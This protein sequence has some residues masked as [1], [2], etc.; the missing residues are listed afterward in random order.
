MARKD[1][2]SAKKKSDSFVELRMLV[3]IFLGVVLLAFVVPGVL[4]AI[5]GNGD[6]LPDDWENQ[7]GITTNAF[8]A[9]NLVG[10]WQMEP[11]TNNVVLDRS[12]NHINGSMSGFSTNP[13][14]AGLFSNALSFATNAQAS[15]STN[16]ALNVSSGQFTFSTW[17]QTTN[18][19][20]QA[21]T[22]ATWEDAS[23]N[24][25]SLQATTNG[26]PFV[27][28]VNSGGDTQ[29]V[30]PATSGIRL[31]DG[32]WHQVAI[33]YTTNQVATVY[34]DGGS[35]ASGSI[36]NWTPSSGATLALGVPDTNTVN[37]SYGLDDTRL[38]NRA[39]SSAEVP[40]L[41][42]TYTDF[43]GNGLTVLEDYQEGLDPFS[44]SSIVTS[45]FISS[46]LV[47][48]Y[49][50]QLP[51]IFKSSGDV[52]TVSSSTF[53]TN[54]LV[55]QIKDSLGNPLVNAPVTFT[56]TSGSDGGLAQTSGGT[57][58][59]SLSLTTDGSGNATV[60][61]KAGAEVLQNNTITA[62]AVSGAGSVSVSFTEY[63][64]TQNGLSLWLKS[65]AGIMIDGSGNITG[66]NDQSVN[67]NNAGTLYSSQPTGRATVLTNSLNSKPVVHMSGGFAGWLNIVDNSSLRPTGTVTMVSVMRPA[68][69]SG[70]YKILAKGSSPSYAL[71][72]N[73][74]GNE[75]SS[76]LYTTATKTLTAT[77]TYTPGQPY[78]VAN[79]Y[80][81]AND[82]LYQSGQS[83]A[84]MALTGSLYYG[85]SEALT[86]GYLAGNYYSGDIA[87]ILVYNRALSPTELTAVQGY[88][89]DKWGVYAPSATWPSSY[90]S[91]VQTLI[92][93][94][95]WTKAQADAYVALAT[96]NSTIPTDMSLWLKA[97]TGIITD[98]NG[99]ITFWNDQ[100]VYQNNAQSLY[101][102]TQTTGRAT[103]LTNSLNSKSVVHMPGA[104]AGWLNVADNL[105][106][107]PTGAVTMISVMR[108]AVNSGNY[109]IL[110]KGTTPSYAL[111]IN[112]SGNEVSSSLYTTSTKTLTA[113]STYTPGQ[114]YLIANVYNGANDTL[115][116][117]GQSMATMALT[118]SLY[119]GSSEA[120]T[121]GYLGG[122]Y[123][124]GDIAE[125]LVYN[126]A[127]SPSELTAVQGYLADQ[128][129]VYAPSA[130]WPSSY[131]SA[132]Q[133]LITA[134]QW[135]KA[136]ADGYVAAETAHS[137]F[138]VDM[139]LWLKADAGVTTDINGNITGWNDQSVYQNNAQSVYGITQTTGRATLLTNSLNSNPVVHMPGTFADWLNIVD[140]SSLR[141]N[142]AVTM[143]S[144]MRPATNS[145]NYK[146]LAKGTTPSYSMGID[147]TARAI[148]SSLYTT[149]NKT[150][151]ATNI[152]TPGQPYLIANVY[153]GTNNSLYQ[154]GQS[155]ATMAL[156]GSL[157]YGNS[158]PLTIGSLTGNYYSG[159]IAEVLVY[160]RALS[161]TELTSVQGY[162]A[163]KWGVYA[164]SATWPSSYTSPVQTLI[165]ANQWTK[166]QAAAYVALASANPTIPVD[167]SLWLKADGMQGSQADV[168]TETSGY[169][170]GWKDESVYQNNA[171]SIYGGVETAS[172]ATLSAN[173]LN[174]K[175][176]VVFTGNL[177]STFSVSDNSSLRP[178]SNVTVISVLQPD[179]QQY[180]TN[181]VV[182]SKQA[183]TPEA[184]VMGANLATQKLSGVVTT[185]STSTAGQLLSTSST[186]NPGQPYVLS[187]TYD[188]TK[189]NL[190]QSGV[191]ANSSNLTGSLS[192]SSSPQSLQLGFYQNNASFCYS[193]KLAEVFVYNRSLSTAELQ[194]VWLYLS[195][196][197]GLQ[198]MLPPTISGTI[199]GNYTGSASISFNP[200]PTGSQIL[201][202][203]DGTVP[204][205]SSAAYT[206]PIV[207][208]ASS[209]LT[210]QYFYDGVPV[211]PSLSAQYFVN[212]TNQIGI[213]D[214]WQTLYFGG[215]LVSGQASALSPG[216]SGL[217]N[218][219]SYLY[220]YNP[221]LYSTNGDGLSDLTNHILGYSA[222]NTDINGYG[223]TNAQQLA[224]G[225]DPFDIGVNPTP[226]AP[227]TPLTQTP[228]VI[229]ID[230][231][232][233]TTIVP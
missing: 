32:T 208:N 111:G 219:Q 72:I 195:A 118:G 88:L 102:I 106:L 227:P 170:T 229:T 47:G 114:P 212:D 41:P 137:T 119:Y 4:R 128:W 164:P 63:C 182:L 233:N 126:R 132:V 109:K 161:P 31:Y 138:P 44:T 155:M 115:Y 56:I 163:D 21:A 74:T 35:E 34:V 30:G 49:N 33:T 211:S 52:Q 136:Q 42:I 17:F 218:L 216:G 160:N 77:G 205:A 154:S 13:Y 221:T 129:G 79:V 103:V 85:S 110:A 178:S 181:A 202:T 183:N 14:V 150:L 209:P 180:V 86:V 87:E 186:Y 57:T 62:T 157:Y 46:G 122:N 187:E 226:S 7:H 203:L 169:I 197:Y 162:L 174:N 67:Q 22:I 101:G 131:T 116:Q 193:G 90:T 230:L 210:Y 80:D 59:T 198:A 206:G 213:S 29:T 222:T 61:Y 124:S 92:A 113:T 171:T 105:S 143:I 147:T 140:N 20:T 167:M 99:N 53:A 192:Y 175:P 232:T 93:T 19:P 37:P 134:N 189:Q 24:S 12:S 40:Q 48:Y 27:S 3:C 95:Q 231:P 76:I 66:W 25:W 217:T 224:L 200:G 50:N 196:K 100:S 207:L 1:L 148:G 75:M 179:A 11:N 78:L 125:V 68:V 188:G 127:L 144:V 112:A 139:T 108:P 39:L 149:T 84:T 185:S 45:S 220:G 225:L 166:A 89:A 159:D 38:Y 36:T 165:A 23:A 28:F 26:A 8:A 184:F 172:R 10:W 168:T 201:Y 156:T 94:N 55:I 91:T 83:M 214:A 191:L 82:T 133:T 177:Q 2:Q 228:P 18:A 141:P 98:T 176:T 152:Y 145:G 54:A 135:T 107:R 190:Y 121:V 151:T 97:G 58:G 123:Y 130:T 104:F 158:E 64:G 194:Q 146:I 9:T 15:F 204:S 51:A 142:G 199:G 6:N 71:G 223:L 43:N 96:A 173:I 153:D 215:L 69:N 60:Y 70:N 16:T 65:D 117:S 81:G 120:L 73:A 5:D